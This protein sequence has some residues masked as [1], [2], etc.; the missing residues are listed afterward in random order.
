MGERLEREQ[1]LK[2][3]IRQRLETICDNLTPAEFEKLIDT[4]ATNQ[5]KGEK[6]PY[7]LAS[8]MRLNGGVTGLRT[9]ARPRHSA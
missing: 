8:A 2:E 7:R 5:I 1:K 4:I 6:R 9:P 3:E